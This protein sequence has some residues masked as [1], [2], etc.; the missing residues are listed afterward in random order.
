M[1]SEGK[2]ILFGVGLARAL[3]ETCKSISINAF[4]RKVPLRASEEKCFSRKPQE[5]E[6]NPLETRQRF[7]PLR[8]RS[9]CIAE[10]SHPQISQMK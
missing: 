6:R 2:Q 3:D 1:N 10:P 8:E 9:S 5:R 7:A 4:A